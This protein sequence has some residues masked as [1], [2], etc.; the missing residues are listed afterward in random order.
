MP[1]AFAYDPA[2]LVLTRAISLEGCMSP[3]IQRY[4]SKRNDTHHL[5]LG[6]LAHRWG[7]HATETGMARLALSDDDA[8][9]RRW[10]V[11]QTRAPWL[12]GHCGPDGEILSL[13]APC[14][15]PGCPPPIGC[16]LNTQP[17]GGGDMLWPDWRPSGLSWSRVYNYQLS[18]CID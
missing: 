17:S 3:S 18:H 5:S 7:A 9:V 2:Y 13:C 4:E 16:H 14:P 10:F 11:E 6:A 15:I 8:M 12:H 1:P